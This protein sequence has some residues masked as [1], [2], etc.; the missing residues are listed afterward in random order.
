MRAPRWPKIGTGSSSIAWSCEFASNIVRSPPAG[1]DRPSESVGLGSAPAAARSARAMSASRADTATRGLDS[2]MRSTSASVISDGNDA[3]D[4]C[5]AAGPARSASAASALSRFILALGRAI[6]LGGEHGVD[7][8]QHEKRHDQRGHHA[9]DDDQRERAL[10]LAAD[11]L[12]ERHGQ[13]S[14][15]RKQGGHQ[16][17]SQL[18]HRARGDRRLEGGSRRTMLLNGAHLQQ[19]KERGL[20]KKREKADP[21]APRER[22]AAELQSEPP[23]G[24]RKR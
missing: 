18:L 2:T 23:A 4:D 12:R 8:G 17:R 14:E 1:L 10:G 21:R 19:A 11:I 16:H 5:A 13:E 22:H 15:E 6:A 7:A 20:A 24:K 3:G 9:A